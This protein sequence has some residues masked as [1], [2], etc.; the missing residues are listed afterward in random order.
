M[1]TKK[2]GSAINAVLMLYMVLAGGAWAAVGDIN[3]I[4]GNGT[5]G[6]SG[7]GGP[8]TSAQLNLPLGVV[9][10]SAGN[11]YIADSGN[12]RIRKIDSAGVIT[13]IAG[14]GTAGYS[15]DGGPA[16]SAMLNFPYRVAVDSAGN[17]YIADTFNHSIRKVNTSGIITTVAGSGTRGYSGDAG[18]AT[19]ASLWSPRSA[20]LR[21]PRPSA[22]AAWER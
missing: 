7:D 8:A 2:F 20:W 14:N 16:T 3:T 15:G 5:A 18:P 9:E 6:F 17:V 1:K 4:A 13:T 19:S 12:N 11:T 10:D 22:A 21:S